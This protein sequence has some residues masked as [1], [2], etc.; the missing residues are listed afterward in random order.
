M[1][2]V[3]FL[4]RLLFRAH[5]SLLLASDVF[6]VLT[7]LTAIMRVRL[8]TAES[9]WIVQKYAQLKS[10]EKVQKAWITEF[11]TNHFIFC[12]GH[13]ILRLSVH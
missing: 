4:S 1:V 11:K 5:Y 2:S 13:L 7:A 12:G 10:A 6:A 3:S 9:I 8:D